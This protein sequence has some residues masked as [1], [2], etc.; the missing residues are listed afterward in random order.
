VFFPVPPADFSFSEVTVMVDG[1]AENAAGLFEKKLKS[2]FRI[3]R[4]QVVLR[5]F[6]LKGQPPG[7]HEGRV[8]LPV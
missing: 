3:Y 2:T 6:I 8:H 1:L 7:R 4:A 5:S